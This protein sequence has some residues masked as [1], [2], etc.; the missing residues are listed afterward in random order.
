MELQLSSTEE[1]LYLMMSREAS[2]QARIK[3]TPF[4]ELPWPSYRRRDLWTQQQLA[5]RRLLVCRRS[6]RRLPQGLV[7]SLLNVKGSP[8]AFVQHLEQ[9]NELTTSQLNNKSSAF[10]KVQSRCS[11]K[12]HA[13]HSAP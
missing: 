11:L 13:Q 12:Q 10:S 7:K 3:V 9:L 5:R 1:T 8:F 2:L 4:L 6:A